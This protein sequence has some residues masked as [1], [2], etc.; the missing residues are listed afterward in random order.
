MDSFNEEIYRE[1]DFD[2]TALNGNLIS[3]NDIK[4]IGSRKITIEEENHEGVKIV[5][6][7]DSED[8]I[9]EIKFVCSC[10]ETKTVL[11]DYNDE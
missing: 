11:L 5:L 1:I 9:K 4:I 6:N 8:N 3:S 10:G 2:S 7:K